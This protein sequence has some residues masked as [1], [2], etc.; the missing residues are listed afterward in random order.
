VSLLLLG[1]SARAADDAGQAPVHEIEMTASNYEF[2]PAVVTVK[3]GEKVRLIVTAANRRHGIAIEGY[4]IDRVLLP[5]EPTTI[6]LT[7]DKA[8]T[9]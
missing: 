9:F 8:G 7:S 4:D 2:D 3:K 1:I 5:G 6:E